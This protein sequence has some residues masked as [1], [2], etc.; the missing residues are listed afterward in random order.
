MDRIKFIDYCKEY[1][2]QLNTWHKIEQQQGYNG[3]NQFVVLDGTL[4]GDYMQYISENIVDINCQL[5]MLEDKLVGF[6][7]YTQENDAAHIE[8]MGTNPEMRGQGIAKN[9][10]TTFKQDMSQQGV[11]KITLEVRKNNES[12][13]KSFSKVAEKS[14]SQP[15]QNYISFEM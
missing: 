9:I 4:L 8:I 12:G 7:C 11:D 14:A 2:T 5:A 6:I 13:I 3:L 10:L 1:C 15:N